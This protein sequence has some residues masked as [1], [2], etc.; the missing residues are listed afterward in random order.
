[1]ADCADEVVDN[2]K[3]NCKKNQVDKEVAVRMDWQEYASFNTKYDMLLA[4]DPF[5]HRCQPELLLKIALH[6]L[7]PGGAML[8]SCPNSQKLLAFLKLAE[9]ENMKVTREKITSDEYM[10]SPT[11]NQVEGEK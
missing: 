6:F 8:L 3:N 5:F 4:S 10:S 9:G 7:L 11:Y 1:M 2:A